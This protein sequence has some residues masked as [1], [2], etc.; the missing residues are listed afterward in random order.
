MNKK[1]ID[2]VLALV[3]TFLVLSP[4]IALGH[5]ARTDSN[6]GH[7]DRTTNIYHCMQEGCDI[8]S[9][10]EGLYGDPTKLTPAYGCS[11]LIQVIRDGVMLT[12]CI[13]PTRKGFPIGVIKK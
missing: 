13:M 2:I 8:K 12:V 4:M 3:V 9:A 11:E 7:Y 10:P 5:T 6:G 1:I